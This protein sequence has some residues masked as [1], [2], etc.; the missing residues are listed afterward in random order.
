MIRWKY[1]DAATPLVSVG[2]YLSSS[3]RPHRDY[4]DG[5]AAGRKLRRLR[6]RSSFQQVRPRFFFRTL[7]L[8]HSY[9]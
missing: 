2:E 6:F 9:Q 5:D 3:Y 8:F 7:V 1:A 4:V